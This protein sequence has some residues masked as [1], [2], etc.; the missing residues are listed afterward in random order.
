[1]N[2]SI[3]LYLCF[4]SFTIHCSPL[5]RHPQHDRFIMDYMDSMDHTSIFSTVDQLAV[6]NSNVNHHSRRDDDIQASLTQSLNL[7]PV[8][9]PLKIPSEAEETQIEIVAFSPLFA[10]IGII[11]VCGFVV[12]VWRCLRGDRA[13]KVMAIKDPDIYMPDYMITNEENLWEFL[14]IL[15]ITT[16]PA[17]EPPNTLTQYPSWKHLHNCCENGT[18]LR[19]T[20]S[21][22]YFPP[23]SPS[24]FIHSHRHLGHSLR[25]ARSAP[26]IVAHQ[27]P[28]MSPSPPSSPRRFPKWMAPRPLRLPSVVFDRE[29]LEPQFQASP[30]YSHGSLPSSSRVPQ[31]LS[32]V[33]AWLTSLPPNKLISRLPSV[34]STPSFPDPPLTRSPQQLIQPRIPMR[35]LPSAELSGSFTFSDSFMRNYARSTTVMDRNMRFEPDRDRHD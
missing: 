23:L 25:Q 22:P 24:L 7:P 10:I 32:G 28:P 16:I 8:A 5:S 29:P 13:R 11:L 4:L 12:H 2:L 14:P 35:P 6:V 18:L 33:K 19:P 9:T 34:P 1:M 15:G 21:A 31:W 30:P 27:I 3:L 26:N 17:L 20:F